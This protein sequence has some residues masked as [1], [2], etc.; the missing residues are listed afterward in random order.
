MQATKPTTAPTLA[1]EKTMSHFYRLYTINDFTGTKCG[2]GVADTHRPSGKEAGVPTEWRRALLQDEIPLDPP[3]PHCKMYRAPLTPSG[4]EQVRYLFKV[5]PGVELPD[6]W[7]WG[8]FVL[9]SERAKAVLEASDDFEH[10]FIE[11]EIQNEQRQRI[12]GIPYYLMNIRRVVKIDELGPYGAIENKYE[13]FCPS[14]SENEFLPVVQRIPELKNHL[15]QLP[16]WRQFGNWEVVYLSEAVFQ[17]LR[18]AGITGLDP[19]TN[20]DGKPGEAI[21]RFE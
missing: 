1:G 14:G 5:Q 6:I 15:S 2:I 7:A 21:A 18:D 3:W 19:Y 11:T 9:V 17:A 4:Y 16:M 20:Y 10:E 12:N 13:M 8:E